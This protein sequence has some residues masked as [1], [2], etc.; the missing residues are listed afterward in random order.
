MGSDEERKRGQSQAM[1]EAHHVPITLDHALCMLGSSTHASF[2]MEGVLFFFS[3]KADNVH[4]VY[5]MII[6][7]H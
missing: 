3:L 1:G 2:E 4:L 5:P 6:Q 7:I